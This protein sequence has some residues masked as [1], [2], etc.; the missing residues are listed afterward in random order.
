MTLATCNLNQ[1]ALDWEGNVERIISSI[2][3]AKSKGAKLRVG[4]ELEITGYGCY[5]HF[6]ESDT[7]L[8]SWEMLSRILKDP[9]CREILLDIGM[10]VM[11][12]NVR[13]NCRVICFNGQL[14]LIRPK[15]YLAQSGNYREM[16][17]FTPWGRPGHTEPYY[18]PRMIQEIVGKTKTVIGDAVISCQDTVVGC[19]TCEEL[20]TP[21]APHSQ[22]SLDGVEVFTNS[23]GSHHELRKL[24]TRFDLIVEATRKAGGIYLYA[25]QQGCDGDRLYYDGSA[26][27]FQNGALLAQGS[28][29]SF[30]DVEVVTA[31]CDIEE[32][33][34]FRCE[35]SRGYQATQARQYTRIDVDFA[36]STPGSILDSK[37]RPSEPREPFF[38]LPEEEIALGP[39]C[40][41]WDY[42]RRSR[43]AGFFLP[44]SGGI[45]S[46]SSA[47]IVHSMCRLVVDA[48]KAGNQQ[49]IRD[50]RTI[51]AEDDWL[52][53]SPQELCE[54]IFHTCY[55][56]TEKNSSKETRRRAKDLG[57]TIN[58]YHINLNIDTVVAAMLGVFTTVT[59]FSP[60]FRT[61]G[62]TVAEGLALQNIQSRLRMVFAYL[63][64]QMLPTVRARRGAGSLLVIGSANVDE[65]LRGY[66]TKYDCSSADL[67]PI[68][69]ISKTDLRRFITWAKDNF[70]LPVLD[71]FIHATPTAELVPFTETYT[72]SDEEEMGLTYDELSVLGRL[73]KVSKLGPFGAWE[74]LLHEWRDKMSPREIAE[75][76][77]TFFDFY[78]INRHKM[79]T[80]T[81]AYHAEQYSPDDNRFD[82]RP[83]L[84]PVL[85]WPY[86]KIEEAL[87]KHES[88]NVQKEL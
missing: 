4:P 17:Y 16:R 83:F 60:R 26:M 13:Y 65:Q 40:W 27:V 49:I 30:N 44:L 1:W 74:K 62:G 42:L 32:V 29:F 87:K 38:H 47:V 28:Q 75:K 54:R 50:V 48:I 71:E 8:H 18:L 9:S 46:A 80:V 34:S 69:G 84:Y 66:Y 23:S 33:R 6:L 59:N 3:I 70:D 55:M 2:Q 86:K 19:E 88:D 37:I 14:L 24:K 77:K 25:N 81:P 56:G 73:R 61:Q 51:C 67:N 85:S 52:P 36:L 5:D 35:P 78:G 12:R 72:Q 15:L 79:T 63:F 43:Q 58:S 64:A 22:M 11:H 76:V 7:F 39:A 82:L 57:Q 10:P 21:A 41:L 31:V 68:G 53:S 20:F 45:D